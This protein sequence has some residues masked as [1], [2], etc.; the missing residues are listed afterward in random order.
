MSLRVGGLL[1][2]TGLTIA[3]VFGSLFVVVGAFMSVCGGIVGAVGM[4]S[5]LLREDTAADVS[6][7]AVDSERGGVA[8]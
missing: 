7:N 2:V 6:A 5:A 1:V 4:E 3:F 8:A